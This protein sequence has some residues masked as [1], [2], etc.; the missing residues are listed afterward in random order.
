VQGAG[1]DDLDAERIDSS[2][3]AGKREAPHDFEDAADDDEACDS[4]Q[5]GEAVSAATAGESTSS[6]IIASSPAVIPDLSS[7]LPSAEEPIN[8]STD[9]LPDLNAGGSDGHNDESVSSA[10]AASG[11]G[12]EPLAPPSTSSY[13]GSMVSSLSSAVVTVY[14]TAR[15]SISALPASLPAM[16]A[17]PAMPSIPSMASYAPLSAASMASMLPDVRALVASYAPQYA[18]DWVEADRSVAKITCVEKKQ[19]NKDGVWARAASCW[20]LCFSV[21]G[22][23]CNALTMSAHSSFDFSILFFMP[24]RLKKEASTRVACGFDSTGLLWLATSEGVLSAHRLV[25]TASSSSSSSAHAHCSA[26]AET[27]SA[28]VGRSSVSSASR[29]DPVSGVA[30][31]EYRLERVSLLL[32]APTEENGAIVLPPQ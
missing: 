16:P 21:G 32:D 6:G 29:G 8:Q 20:F 24:R 19:R 17:M 5:T 11:S 15:S 12:D 14:S 4:P 26:Q 7:A 27:A 3:S 31:V 9:A 30:T 1:A 18:A 10:A 25:A 13:L 23:C 22:V 2:A 28:A